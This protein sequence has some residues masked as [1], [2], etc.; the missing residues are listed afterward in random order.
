MKRLFLVIGLIA[1]AGLAALSQGDTGI[2]PLVEAQAQ[3][4]EVLKL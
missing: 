4:V 3:G 1:V 2:Q